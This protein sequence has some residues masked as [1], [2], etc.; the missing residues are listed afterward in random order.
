[1]SAVME[2]AP[3][4]ERT[5]SRDSWT[6]VFALARFEARRLLMSLPVIVGF[7]MYVAWI[8]WNAQ[9]YADGFPALQNVDRATQGGPLLVGLAVLLAVN[10]AVLRSG[11]RDTERHL[12]VLVMG[13]G[14][15]TAAHLLS[16]GPAVLLTAVCVTGQFGWEALKSGALGHGSVGEL[17]VGPL[18]VL[19]FGAVGVLMARLVASTF[20][21]P[22]LLVVF[23]FFFVLGTGLG[24]ESGWVRWLYPVVGEMSNDTLPS[25]LIG[26]PAL[27]H[28]VYLAGLGLSL[29]LLA[30]L[31]GGGGRARSA[32]ALFVGALALTVL[33]GTAQA[34][35]VPAKTTAARDRVTFHPEQVQTCVERAGSR[36][37]A[38]PEWRGRTADWASVVEH[39]QSLAGGTAHDQRL[40]VRQR[41]DATYGLD[42]DAAIPPSKAA[43]QVTVGT[44]W[45]GNRVPEFSAAVAAVLI[46]GD[47]NAAGGLC[48]GRM[49]TLMWIAL[50]WESDP[51][52]QLRRVRLDDSVTGSAIV[53]SPTNSMSMTEGQT[54]VVRELLERPRGEIAAKVKSRWSELTAPKVTTAR[55]AELL[56]VDAKVKADSCD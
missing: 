38:F 52:T 44:N 56:G 2:A 27:W 15:R 19:L 29:A 49:V 12:G 53:L 32:R 41:I 7:L 9:D 43:H 51:I 26:R 50:A 47:E 20:A 48:D 33:G 13:A 25:D 18:T 4:A 28:A 17:L 55:A 10:Q 14:R 16:V 42:G 11:R 31:L 1:M 23:L 36:Y 30:V 3:P 35:G 6:A 5:V 37:C 46:A 24:G 45:G 22:L 54:T 39:V 21:A 34:Q 8:V 40:L